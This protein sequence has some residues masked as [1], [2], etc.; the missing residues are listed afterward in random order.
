M[1]CRAFVSKHIYYTAFGMTFNLLFCYDQ[2][3]K[4]NNSNHNKTT[5]MIIELSFCLLHN[6]QNIIF[7]M[8][9][10]I[11]FAFMFLILVKLNKQPLCTS[12]YLPTNVT[13]QKG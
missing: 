5:N 10:S 9:I 12:L 13:T 11:F 3:Y 8:C 7:I 1:L 6:K 2:A 4:K